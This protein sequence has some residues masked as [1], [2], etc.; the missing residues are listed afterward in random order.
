M[1]ALASIGGVKPSAT[2]LAL[3]EDIERRIDPE[4][5]EDFKDQWRDFL[6]GR[7]EGDIFTPRRKKLSPPTVPLPSVHIND[8]IEDLD[9]MMQM[10]LV[11]VSASL[12]TAT[13]SPCLRANYGTGIMS[14]LFG[15]ELFMMPRKAA[16]LPTTRPCNDPEWIRAMVERGMPDLRSAL[17]GKVFAFGEYCAELFARYPKA[18]KY[19]VMYH[20]DL[21]GALDICELL[22][23]T[24]I[25]YSMYDEP[26]LVHAAM[27]L[28]TDTYTAF[29]K[30]WQLM[31]PPETDMN[32]H[33]GG[34]YH[35][36]TILLRSDSAMNLSPELYRE[37]SLPYDKRL[38]DTFGGGAVHFCGR[39]DHYITDLCS[40]N[41]VFGINMSQPECND[42]ESI[43]QATVDRGIPL[44]GFS[45]ARAEQDKGRKGGFSGHLHS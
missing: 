13:V 9:L 36:G 45:R 27:E 32:P 41:G 16:T 39:G 6:Y 12:N 18:Q 11:G 43:Y 28:I 21:Q 8:A 4:V 31:F 15:A 30:A 10:Q 29:M 24:E 34:L 3:L 5:E 26:E 7:Y 23:G 17:G 1:S 14:S 37:F 42:M 2:T 33:W 20:P 22:W 40:L 25:F 44:L 35:R 38:L 19:V